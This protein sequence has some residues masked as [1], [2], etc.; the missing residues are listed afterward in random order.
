MCVCVCVGKSATTTTTTTHYT[1]PRICT[2]LMKPNLG[3]VREVLSLSLPRVRPR[4]FWE[5]AA[6]WRSKKSSIVYVV[7]VV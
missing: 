6:R 5:K 4:S 2:A 7:V 3:E 1:P